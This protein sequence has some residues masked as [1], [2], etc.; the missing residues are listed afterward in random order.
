MEKW[1]TE[2]VTAGG[3]LWTGG[4][5]EGTSVRPAVL[6]DNVR[7]KRRP[8]WYAKEVFGRTRGCRW[9]SVGQTARLERHKPA[10]DPMAPCRPP[11]GVTHDLATASRPRAS[12]RGGREW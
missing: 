1:I 7:R 8:G 10:T 6:R 4:H 2:A 5:R 11:R 12:N 9:D 3:V